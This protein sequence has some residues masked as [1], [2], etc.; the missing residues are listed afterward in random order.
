MSPHFRTTRL[1]IAV[2]AFFLAATSIM[3]AAR[4]GDYWTPKNFTPV[5]DSA[6][7]KQIHAEGAAIWEEGHELYKAGEFKKAIALFE[8]SII[9][10]QMLRLPD[11]I[12]IVTRAIKAAACMDRIKSSDINQL[13]ELIGESDDKSSGSMTPYPNSCLP[14]PDL[15]AGVRKRIAALQQKSG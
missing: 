9:K 15:V 4:A 8:R 11:D 14:F 7:A 13:K 6:K 3:S 2:S 12:E 10:Y 5:T 1:S